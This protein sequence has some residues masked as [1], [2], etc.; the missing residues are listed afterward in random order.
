MTEGR[1]GMFVVGVR[2]GDI[3]LDSLKASISKLEGVSDVHFNYL[4]RKFTVYYD[5]GPNTL[6]LINGLLEGVIRTTR[7]KSWSP[8]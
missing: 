2:H 5:G 6:E 4:T 7:K 1:R 8:D 3:D